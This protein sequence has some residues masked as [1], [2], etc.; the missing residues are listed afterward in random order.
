MEVKRVPDPA[1]LRRIEHLGAESN[2]QQGLLDYVAMMTDVDLPD[3]D[4]G[5]TED[6]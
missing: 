1:G 6:E 4:E 2:R 3:D 5:A